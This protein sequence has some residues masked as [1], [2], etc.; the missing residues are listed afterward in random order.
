MRWD[1]L[2]ELNWITISTFFFCP[3]FEY[4]RGVTVYYETIFR[5]C[6]YIK[7]TVYHT[8]VTFE[9]FAALKISYP[10]KRR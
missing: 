5:A 3:N 1:T 6:D 4:F 2:I 9:K 7:L 8:C 10:E